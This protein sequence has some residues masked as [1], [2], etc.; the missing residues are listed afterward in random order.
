[1]RTIVAFAVLASVL[2]A[3]VAAAPPAAANTAAWEFTTVGSEDSFGDFSLGTAFTVNSAVTVTG[4]GIYGP[5]VGNLVNLYECADVACSSTGTLLASATVTAGDTAI[6]HFVY[7]LGSFGTLATNTGYLIVGTMPAGN[8]LVWD[9][10]GFAT[11][12]AF[13]VASYSDRYTADLSGGFDPEVKGSAIN[14][15]FGPNLLIGSGGGTGGGG[16][17]AGAVPEPA[18]WAM[19]IAGFGLTGAAM[20]RRRVAVAIA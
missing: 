15:Y 2:A 12:P 11:N 9:N 4:L 3:P 20:R 8:N 19:L 10:A 18:S 17:G 7:K 5:A 14:G 6:G 13:N 1:M 16:G